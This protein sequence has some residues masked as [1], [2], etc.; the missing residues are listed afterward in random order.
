MKFDLG[1]SRTPIVLKYVGY[2]RHA[3]G[4]N[5]NFTYGNGGIQVHLHAGDAVVI[6]VAGDVGPGAGVHQVRVLVLQLAIGV[7]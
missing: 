7:L 5:K 6:A 3:Q 1:Q 2:R 4:W